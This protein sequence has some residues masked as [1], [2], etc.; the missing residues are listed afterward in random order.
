MKRALL[1][2][3]MLLGA[4]GLTIDDMLAMQRISDPAVS[5]DGKWVAFAVRDTDM[6]A[7]KGRL[8]VWLAPVDGS[9]AATRLTTDPANDSD[10]AWSPDGKLVYF[11]SSR[12]GSAQVWRIAPTGGEAQQMTKL[13]VDVGGFKLFPDGRRLVLAIDVWPEAKSLADSAKTDEQ[14]AKSKVKARIYTELLFRHWDAWEDG[15]FNHLFVWDPTK[16]DTATDLTPGATSDVPPGPFGGMDQISI[17]PDGKTVAYVQRVGGRESAWTTNTDVFLVSASGGKPGRSDREE[18]GVRLRAGVLARRQ[19]DRGARDGA[20][21]LRGRSP[22]H[23]DL[24]R[25]HARVARDRGR[26]GPLR[27]G[28]DVERRRPHDLHVGGQRRQPLAVGDRRRERKRQGDRRKRHERRRARRGRPDR[29]RQGYP[30]AA[31]PSC[32]ASSPTGA[33]SSRS[34]TSTTTA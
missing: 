8:D 1:L 32:S 9:A 14:K 34:R 13:P 18:Q 31:R 33:T 29:V 7:N 26:V 21:R 24:R 10:P 11:L 27:R 25:V 3:P 2:L 30:R 28:R 16:P 15:K 4:K 22:A 12:G 20:P 19:V 5:P 23:H 17:A 6:D